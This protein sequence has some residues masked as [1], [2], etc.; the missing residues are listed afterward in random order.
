MAEVYS[1]FLVQQGL[2]NSTLEGLS[3]SLGGD[4]PTLTDVKFDSVGRHILKIHAEITDTAT[5]DEIALGKMALN[6]LMDPR[7]M[8]ILDAKP[9]YATPHILKAMDIIARLGAV[10]E[11]TEEIATYLS[12]I[13]SLLSE[14]ADQSDTDVL[15]GNKLTIIKDEDSDSATISLTESEIITDT[16]G[17]QYARK[18]TWHIGNIATITYENTATMHPGTDQAEDVWPY[19]LYDIGDNQTV[20]VLNKSFRDWGY[21]ADLKLLLAA[22]QDCVEDDVADPDALPSLPELDYVETIDYPR[23]V[24]FDT[25]TMLSEIPHVTVTERLRYSSID[26]VSQQLAIWGIPH[27]IARYTYGTEHIGGILKAAEPAKYDRPNI[28]V[29]MNIAGKIKPVV[30]TKYVDDPSSDTETIAI[31]NTFGKIGRSEVYYHTYNNVDRSQMIKHK[32]VSFETPS[33][34]EILL[35]SKANLHLKREQ[36]LGINSGS[37]KTIDVFGTTVFLDPKFVENITRALSSDS[38]QWPLGTL[39]IV[40]IAE[41]LTIKLVSVARNLRDV[42]STNPNH[43]PS[44]STPS[45]GGMSTFWDNGIQYQA[46][47]AVSA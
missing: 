40:E 12:N 16:Q 36:L 8:N 15:E 25:D 22:L 47:H 21:T 37:I 23:E 43:G 7:P 29:H 35:P 13:R 18:H 2:F 4:H 45:N 24:K 33:E 32:V 30:L 9:H 6:G 31:R 20:D 44:G 28:I 38:S 10:T 1:Y 14:L 27:Q 5:D 17:T 39:C 11:A 41:D 34:P 19:T 42:T 46:Y 3:S 26:N